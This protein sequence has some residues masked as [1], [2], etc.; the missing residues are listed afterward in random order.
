[1]AEP[2][3]AVLIGCS[4]FPK[5]REEL[6][7]LRCPEN[8]VDGMVEILTARPWGLFPEQQTH[9]L[10][11][12]PHN[13]ILFKIEEVLKRAA[14]DDTVLIYYSGHG[15]C[16]D[17]GW[18]YLAAAN[19]DTR[20][21]GSTSIPAQLIKSYIDNGASTK[22]VLILDCCFSGAV[23]KVFLRGA[24]VD[25]ELR[26]IAEGRGT[27]IL[28]ASTKLQTARER[29]GDRYGLLTKHIIY[30]VQEREADADGDGL[31]SMNE[32]YKYVH[33]RVKDEG[34]QEPQLIVPEARGDLFLARTGVLPRKERER[35][36]KELL[37]DLNKRAILSDE[38]MM[39]AI[40]I[41]SQTSTELFGEN[42]RYDELLD[43]LLH[44]QVE[45]G[46]FYTQWY[47]IGSATPAPP[48]YAP[49]FAAPVGSVQQTA[50]TGTPFACVLARTLPRNPRG[51]LSLAFSPGGSYLAT[52]GGDGKTQIWEVRI[53]ALVKEFAGPEGPVWTVAFTPD[54]R[55]V[56]AA[57]A[58]GIVR[59]WEFSTGAL[60]SAL[61][62]HQRPVVSV[63]VNPQGD[64][65]ASGSYDGLVKIWDVENGT[66]KRSLGSGPG[67]VN[68]VA[69]HING[70]LV[71]AAGLVREIRLWNV[72]TGELSR[73]L[74]DQRGDVHAIAFSAG[75]RYFAS[76]GKDATVKL[77]ET[78]QWAL[79]RS[80][81]GEPHP[82]LSVAFSSD[83]RLL[84]AGSS[85]GV[86]RI[87]ETDNCELVRSVEAGHISVHA[88]AFSPDNRLI[89]S[90][91]ADETARLWNWGR[92]VHRRAL[93]G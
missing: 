60:L 3:H 4:E 39:R 40:G 15:R 64:L 73:T 21:L 56:I 34:P 35:K 6:T 53:G 44:Q 87:W 47:R 2:R 68:A 63:A 31:V 28:T 30:G 70:E 5:A 80:F 43:R 51:V 8:D 18:L 50:G 83:E 29:E 79:K 75:G 58:D 76:G 17:H 41:V 10:K 16:D 66:L 89:A 12:K 9:V 20:Y 1:M 86:I 82:V 74:P 19:T 69:F 48:R 78:S 32:L 65:I 67:A 45:V 24:G 90:A 52:G 38:I 84:A 25:N 92:A 36:L 27:F 33:Q 91:G 11:N 37:F 26:H 72:G 7:Q 85:D 49:T 59:V 23:G 93:V 71:A 62:C 46:E 13:E 54:G 77:W 22:V 88:V 61:S 42:R 81:R 55:R 57:G 14:K